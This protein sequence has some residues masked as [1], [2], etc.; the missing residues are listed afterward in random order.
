MLSFQ[1]VAVVSKGDVCGDPEQMIQENETHD[2]QSEEFDDLSETTVESCRDDDSCAD[3]DVA[4]CGSD[5]YSV[6]Q[7]NAF[8][9][10]TKGKKVEIGKFFPDLD[11][12]VLSVMKVRQECSLEVLSQQKRFRLKKYLTAIRQGAKPVRAKRRA[13]KCRLK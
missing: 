11:K 6:E 12:F 1:V 8:L 5:L 7:I 3:F 9:D 13:V 4:N 10:E 2:G